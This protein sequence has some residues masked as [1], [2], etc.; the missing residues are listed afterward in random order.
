[1][2]RLV[3]KFVRTSASNYKQYGF[4]GFA[5]T[6]EETVRFLKGSAKDLELALRSTNV[7]DR[8]WD[9]LVL[10]D[11]ATVGMMK[12]VRDQYGFVERVD[13]I[14]STGTCSSQ[15]MINTFT[16]E[17]REEMKD[18]LHVTANTSSEGYLE[19]DWFLHLE[20]VWEDGWDRDLKTIPAREVTDRAI[21][22]YR[23]FDPKRTIVHYMQPHT[24]FVKRPE[25]DSAEV[26][27]HGVRGEGMDVAELH[28]EAGYSKKELWDAH[29]EN[30]QYVL[31]DVE[32]LVSNISAD[33]V[34]IS[35]DHGQAFGE[36]GVW[37][38]PGFSTRVD[39][40]RK[41]PWCKTVASDSGE[42]SPE[43]EPKPIKEES[44]L[45][46]EEKL[47]HLGYR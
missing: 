30:L 43:Y 16:E 29:I 35:A 20:E 3:R 9:V 23:E 25:M 40:I 26:S 46:V 11:C 12:Q 14:Y 21:Y 32:L 13:E 31:D 47:R 38:H 33:R 39:S 17:Y 15:W 6:G 1:M 22:Y 10:L 7:Y 42:Y 36:R 44:K 28:H 2:R 8:E 18:T 5:K 37:G 41:V 4:S 27:R 45:S 34:V 19:E 24:P